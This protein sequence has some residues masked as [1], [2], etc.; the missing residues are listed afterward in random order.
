MERDQFSASEYI[1]E[2]FGYIFRKRTSNGKYLAKRRDYNFGYGALL[3]RSKIS[4][5]RIGA[6]AV[7]SRA[8]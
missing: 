5:P 6:A 8:P 2:R 1:L 3:E 7:T 4:T